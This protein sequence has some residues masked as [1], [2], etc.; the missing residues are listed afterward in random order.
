MS[1]AEYARAI[2]DGQ[3]T[4]EKRT[5]LDTIADLK[6]ISTK[7]AEMIPSLKESVNPETAKELYNIVLDQEALGYLSGFYAYHIE[8][9]LM[10]RRYNDSQEE[11]FR[12][13]AL[14]ACNKSIEYFTKFADSY[15]V[16]F[17]VERL[18]R[19]GV[20][21]VK[22]MLETLKKEISTIEKWKPRNY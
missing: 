15:D 5:P 1:I 9:A 7:V 13:D 19:H 12:Q 17:Q 16:R 22:Q 21:D 2:T 6:Q 4:F 18:A 8:A 11:S 10:L 20:I 14:S 3:T